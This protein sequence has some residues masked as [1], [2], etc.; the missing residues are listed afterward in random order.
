MYI[1]K[2][3]YAIVK[4]IEHWNIT[5]FPEEHRQ[6]L[7]LKGDFSKFIQKEYMTEIIETDFKKI[8]NHYFISNSKVIIS[9]NLINTEN[10]KLQFSTT[11]Q[12]NW[13]DFDVINPSKINFKDEQHLFHSVKYDEQFWNNYVFPNR[14]ND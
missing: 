9:G 7:N 8:Q 1:D 2:N 13:C 6:G 14:N 4:I 10:E 5:D 12:A 3:D 11:I